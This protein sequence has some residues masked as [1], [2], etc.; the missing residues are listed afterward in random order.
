MSFYSMP[1][2]VSLSLDA[3]TKPSTC[4]LPLAEFTILPPHLK[5]PLRHVFLKRGLSGPQLAALLHPKV[6]ELDLSDSIVSAGLLTTVA[7]CTNLRKLNLNTSFSYLKKSV[8]E[9]NNCESEGSPDSVQVAEVLSSNSHLITL[10]LRNLSCVT[11]S[12]LSCL[13]PTVTNLDL[14]GC[15]SVTDSGVE[16]LVLQCPQ[17]ASLSLS[18]TKLTDSGLA[19]LGEGDCRNTLK[20]VRVDGCVAITDRGIHELLSGMGRG[21]ASVLEILIFHRCPKVTERS[22]QILE[23]FLMEAGRAVRQLTFTVY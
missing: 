2:L 5:D 11:D 16:Q 4:F 18:K 14:G 8:G 6:T 12:V 15:S 3:L 19:K 9:N 1:S 21:G 10:Y 17:L 20:E 23:E 13:P 22:R 7:S